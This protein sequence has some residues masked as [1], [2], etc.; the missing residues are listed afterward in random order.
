MSSIFKFN[1]SICNIFFVF[2]NIDEKQRN[3][4]CTN[5]LLYEEL[6]DMAISESKKY[7]K[8]NQINKTNK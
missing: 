8:K 3:F 5:Q 6:S 1:N 4:L 7:T 2:V